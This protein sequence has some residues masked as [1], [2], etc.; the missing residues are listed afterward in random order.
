MNLG[1]KI[2]RIEAVLE[3]YACRSNYEGPRYMV[4]NKDIPLDTFSLVMQDRGERA[5]LLMNEL[6]RDIDG[7][8]GICSTSN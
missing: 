3:F 6:H 1:E 5:R 2:A 7:H 4:F 8:I